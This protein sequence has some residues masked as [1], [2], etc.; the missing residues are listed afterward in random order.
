MKGNL[1]N[2][3]KSE[4]VATVKGVIDLKSGFG[5]RR[6]TQCA[7]VQWPKE[8]RPD[9]SFG[10]ATESRTFYLYGLDKAAVR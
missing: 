6:H 9:V 8:A 10:I 2:Y 1:L 5:I 4:G 7:E 3:Y